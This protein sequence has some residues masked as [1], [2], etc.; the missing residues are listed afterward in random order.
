M[1]IFLPLSAIWAGVVNEKAIGA[2]G[3]DAHH[4]LLQGEFYRA[5]SNSTYASNSSGTVVDRG[6]QM[7][8][9]TCAS[10]SPSPFARKK[11]VVEW[12]DEAILVGREFGFSRGEA[13]ERG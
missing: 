9:C 1:C 2:H 10:A 8:V 3:P 12:D 5:A 7:S 13:G 11:S 6:R 4:R